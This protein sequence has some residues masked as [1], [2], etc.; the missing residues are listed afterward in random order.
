MEDAVRLG[1]SSC[2]LGSPVYHD[3][4]ILRDQV[5]SKTLGHGIEFVAVGPEVK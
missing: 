1:V 5:V 4:M 2:L 3:G